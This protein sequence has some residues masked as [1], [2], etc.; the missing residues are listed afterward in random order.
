MRLLSSA[1]VRGL[2]RFGPSLLV[3]ALA[4]ACGTAPPPPP[5]GPGEVVQTLLAQPDPARPPL[6]LEARYV[7]GEADQPLA[8]WH[9]DVRAGNG[10]VVQS[11]KL[12]SSLAKG[13]FDLFSVYDVDGDGYAD[14]VVNNGYGAGPLPFTSLFRYEAAERKFVQDKGY[15][16]F[17]FP[18]PSERR[19]CTYHELRISATEGYVRSEYCRAP[20]QWKQRRVCRQIDP[21]YKEIED[22]EKAWYKK[23]KPR[24]Q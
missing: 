1:A 21:C 23:Q 20:V 3:L 8:G 9:L 6:R 2:V 7:G 19:G 13:K 18:V 24:T 10:E 22:Y 16:G 17:S 5:A 11:L 4:S 14:V 15:R 12:S